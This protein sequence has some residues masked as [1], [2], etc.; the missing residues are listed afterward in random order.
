MLQRLARLAHLLVGQR[1]VVVRVGVGGRELNRRLIRVDG[2]LDASGFVEHVAQVEIGKRIAGID[3]NRRTV[4]PFGERVFLAV[5][6]QRAQI[7]VRGGV[8]GIHFENL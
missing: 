6:V 3:L 7:D 1:D 5:V 4:V 8:N 2:L